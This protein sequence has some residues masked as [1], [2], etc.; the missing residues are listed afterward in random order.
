MF[1]KLPS[2]KR[3]IAKVELTRGKPRVIWGH[4]EMKRHTRQRCLQ[5]DGPAEQELQK[6]QS[7]VLWQQDSTSRRPAAVWNPTSLSHTPVHPYTAGE[8]SPTPG[9][10]QRFSAESKDSTEQQRATRKGGR[11]WEKDW[12]GAELSTLS[13]HFP[14]QSGLGL[15]LASDSSSLPSPSL[16]SRG[17]ERPPEPWAP[18]PEQEVSSG[19]NPGLAAPPLEGKREVKVLSSELRL[20]DTGSLPPPA[21]PWCFQ[22]SKLVVPGTK[23]KEWHSGP[24][25]PR[26][27]QGQPPG[28]HLFVQRQQWYLYDPE[29]VIS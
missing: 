2:S 13:S 7:C 25:G 10:K 6:K 28:V 3:S 20:A 12:P 4:E 27:V 21:A 29:R 8:G 26:E 11:K 17:S 1:S 22:P 19:S 24:G 9:G 18:S 23:D 16:P 5:A 14:A 15:S